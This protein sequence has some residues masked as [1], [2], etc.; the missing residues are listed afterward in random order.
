MEREWA[1]ADPPMPIDKFSINF[2]DKKISGTGVCAIEKI[3]V[4]A[5]CDNILTF[6]FGEATHEDWNRRIAASREDNAV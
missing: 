3:R 5:S 1:D 6:I 2:F 4:L